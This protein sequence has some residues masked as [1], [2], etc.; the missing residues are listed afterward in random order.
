[1][2]GD[3]HYYGRP[4]RSMADALLEGGGACEPLTHLLV[5]AV[6]DTG[7]PARARFRYYGGET[8]GGTTHVAPVYLEGARETHLLT[9]AA[10]V[11]SGALVAGADLVDAYARAHDVDG[12]PPKPREGG[13]AGGGEPARFPSS[14]ASG[15]PANAAR[16][17]GT[18]PLYAGRAVQAPGGA[19]GPASVVPAPQPADCAYSP[20]ARRARLH[21]RRSLRPRPLRRD[22][23]HVT[24]FL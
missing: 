12:P 21:R 10:S 23:A 6:H 4:G 1:M 2:F 19:R 16:Y 24:R 14:M 17:P 11:R 7:Q 18:V 15:Y 9:G 3:L 8:E 20:L 22:G 13:G 5:A